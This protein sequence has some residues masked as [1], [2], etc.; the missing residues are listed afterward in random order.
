[1]RELFRFFFE[2]EMIFHSIANDATAEKLFFFAQRI[3]INI[4]TQYEEFCVPF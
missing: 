2:I 1:M 3:C 4:F